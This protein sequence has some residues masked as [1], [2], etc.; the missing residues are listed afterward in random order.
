[1]S[2]IVQARDIGKIWTALERTNG[3]I[4]ELRTA[5]V[6]IDGTNGLRG[7]LRDFIAKF[8]ADHAVRLSAV[9][10]RVEEGF[11]FG[12]RLY[13]VERHKPGECIGK[14]A[15]DRYVAELEENQRRETELTTEMKKSRDAMITALVAA[16]ITSVASI[17]VALISLKGTP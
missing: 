1:M 2:D 15:L 7:E 9:E 3:D 14:A 10:D 12:R 17:I 11:E 13:D 5:I 16:I 8:D 6:G 4:R